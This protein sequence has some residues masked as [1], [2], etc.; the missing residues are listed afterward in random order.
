VITS[1]N[2]HTFPDHQ[3][4][5]VAMLVLSFDKGSGGSDVQSKSRGVRNVETN[6]TRAFGTSFATSTTPTN[7][8][9]MRLFLIRHAETV[10][11]S[12]LLDSSN[13]H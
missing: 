13:G 12:N 1:Q 9:R 8:N 2:R 10:S 4:V 6:T 7:I 3:S 5:C 11:M